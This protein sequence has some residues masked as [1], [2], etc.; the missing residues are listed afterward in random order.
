MNGKGCTV[1]VGNIDF[2]IPEEKIIEELSAVGRVISFRIVTDR[3]TGKSKGYGFCTYES[4]I[5]ADMAVN[6]LRI[7]LNNRP[8]KINYA[9]NNPTSSSAA[10]V[11]E[12][13]K[14]DSEVLAET[15]EKMSLED[16]K[17]ILRHLKSI[18]INKPEELKKMLNK[19]PSLLSALLHMI[20]ILGLAPKEVLEGLLQKSF[21]VSKQ[22]AQILTRILQYHDY[23]VDNLPSPLREK[24]IKIRE[25]LLRK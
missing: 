1:F 16:T 17:E 14:I 24:A 19:T 12:E 4:P 18:A 7:M 9:D 6:K 20:F 13:A 22:N 11:Q 25:K 3:V 2:D 23:E 5:I 8:V 10:P 15:L 21:S